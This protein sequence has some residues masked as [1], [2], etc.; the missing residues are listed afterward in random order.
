MRGDRGVANSQKRLLR[1][2]GQLKTVE[3][4]R[5]YF[6]QNSLY[7]APDLYGSDS[8]QERYFDF[9]RH[10]EEIP[11]RGMYLSSEGRTVHSPDDA[12][13]G[14]VRLNFERQELR[15]RRAVF[16]QNCSDFY[17]WRHSFSARTSRFKFGQAGS[18]ACADQRGRLTIDAQVRFRVSAV[19][20]VQGE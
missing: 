13:A 20:E 10:E 8:S 4:L 5:P 15:D 12:P 14:G 17:H 1:D 11:P 6:L 7:R 18:T 19:K 2:P 9:P 3:I 16:D